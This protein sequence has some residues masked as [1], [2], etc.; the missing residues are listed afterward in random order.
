MEKT[1]PFTIY[2]LKA[3]YD[4]TNALSS[5]HT[6]NPADADNL[7]ENG[8]LYILDAEAK[9]PWWKGYFAVSKN[10]LQQHKGA[11][12]F[13]P[14]GT[15]WFA[16]AFG[17]VLH[18]LDD[19]AYEYDFG[20]RIT[21][22]SLDPKELK[23]A[24][25]IEPG[26]ARRKRTQVPVSTE[27]T[28][29]DFDGNSEIIK[30]LTGKVRK[31]YKNLFKNATGSVGLKVS[32]KIEP[33]ELPKICAELLKL[34]ESEEFKTTFP[35][36]QNISP[37]KDPTTIKKLDEL[38]I[39]S[40]RSQDGRVTLAIPDIVDYRDNTCCIFSGEGKSSAIFPDISLE[41][42]YEFYGDPN[43]LTIDVLKEYRMS[44]ADIEGYLS[45]KAYNVYRTLIFDA[46]LSAED[47]VY[48]LCE[49]DWYRVEKSFIVRLSNYLDKKCED[50]DLLPY[51]HD[52]TKDGRAV[53]SEAQYN[54]AIPA[55]N[56]KFICLDQTDISPTGNTEIEP[57]DIYRIENDEQTH[58]GFRGV[59][60]HLKISTRSSSLSHLF[61]QG[62]NSIELIQLEDSSRDK[63][64]ALV[65][66]KLGNND[67]TE[68]LAPIKSHDF[69][70][71]FGIVTHKDRAQKSDNLPL[72]SKISLMRNMQR[73]DLFKVPSALTFIDDQSPK[74]DGHPKAT[75]IAVEVHAIPGGK[76][77]VR[78]V[79][80]QGFDESKVVKGC[81]KEL[82]ESSAGSR[83]SL[84]VRKSGE[85]EL[86]SHHSWPY[87][88]L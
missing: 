81:P 53:Y 29:L 6:L 16:L 5:T 7:P 71:I 57:C 35:N 1:R 72:F 22:N 37:I 45:G 88:A 67:E 62:V 10:L 55:W 70:V 38:L 23:S 47:A 69:K 4:K 76:N 20:L 64:C 32:L 36:I 74:K 48:H 73:L 11:L 17:Q 60:Y 68:Y 2:L 19:R 43:G 77:E 40:L 41:H 13:L 28:Y 49:G 25:M 59:L 78:P 44:L 58:S 12:I 21:L 82:R 15:R 63:M 65:V 84:S 56:S 30:S 42:F 46:E 52:A 85:G 66:E 86:S 18:H 31:E 51:N 8:V 50:S 54:A 80:G 75:K 34:Y 27:L 33:N 26:I 3:G 61:N 9:P 14:V 83:F 87:S 24:D 79:A 39:Q